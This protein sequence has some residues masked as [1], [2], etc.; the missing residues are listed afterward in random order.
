MSGT[1][2]LN[3]ENRCVKIPPQEGA[4]IHQVEKFVAKFLMKKENVPRH[5]RQVCRQSDQ[6]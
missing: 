3:G 2:Y 6:P 4:M 1:D 5:G